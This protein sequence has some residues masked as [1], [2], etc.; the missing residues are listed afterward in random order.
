MKIFGYMLSRRILCFVY[1]I[2]VFVIRSMCVYLCKGI[3]QDLWN[4]ENM[5]SC[6]NMLLLNKQMSIV[7]VVHKEMCLGFLI[8]YVEVQI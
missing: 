3:I 4:N 5:C 6:V 2:Y 8:C 1:V 7:Y